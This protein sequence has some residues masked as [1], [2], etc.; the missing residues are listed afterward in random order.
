MPVPLPHNELLLLLPDPARR[1]SER[2]F[3]ALGRTDAGRLLHAIKREAVVEDLSG[4]RGVRI[5]N[6]LIGIA[7]GAAMSAPSRPWILS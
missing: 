1:K 7:A 4:P 3:R 5:L 2:R 6:L